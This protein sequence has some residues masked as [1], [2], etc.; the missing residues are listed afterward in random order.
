MG[1]SLARLAWA[2]QFPGVTCESPPATSSAL[3]LFTFPL[4]PAS[5]LTQRRDP[6]AEPRQYQAP[7]LTR[8]RL[9][10]MGEQ[11]PSPGGPLYSPSLRPSPPHPDKGMLR[12]GHPS[13]LP[14]PSLGPTETQL[15]PPAQ[16]RSG[17]ALAPLPATA[18]SRG[19]LGPGGAFREVSAPAHTHVRTPDARRT[20]GRGLKR[21]GGCLRC[22]GRPRQGRMRPLARGPPFPPPALP[23]HP[24]RQRGGRRPPR[25][26]LRH[27][28]G[29]PLREYRQP[30][31]LLP[32]PGC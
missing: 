16:T 3:F 12:P 8:G 21:G 19:R 31:G 24:R 22:P 7:S 17:A 14:A 30:L 28:E 5:R 18:P 1:A 13:T 15:G 20:T 26:K 27:G 25:G 32:P 6:S 29:A 23:G 10:E 2:P 4:P 11:L 9:E